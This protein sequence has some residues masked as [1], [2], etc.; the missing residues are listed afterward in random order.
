MPNPYHQ[1]NAS[2]IIVNRLKNVPID[3]KLLMKSFHDL[4]T[5]E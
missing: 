2:E 3:K 1:G 5:V 4:P